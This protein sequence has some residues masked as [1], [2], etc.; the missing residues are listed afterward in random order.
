M[1]NKKRKE[2][3][4]TIRGIK[5]RKFIKN[6]KKMIDLLCLHTIFILPLGK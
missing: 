4:S 6:L 2:D 1:Y 5:Q 3:C